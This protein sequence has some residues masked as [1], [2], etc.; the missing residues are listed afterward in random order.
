MPPLELSRTVG[1]PER[2]REVGE[3]FLG[4]FVDLCGLRPDERVL[5]VGSGVGRIA[6]PLAGYLESGTYEG[7]DVIAASVRWCQENITPRHPNFVFQHADVYNGS[8]NPTGTIAGRRLRVPVRGT[9]SFDFLYLAWIV[10][11]H[12]AAGRR[13]LPV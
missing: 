11:P 9:A 1:R 13:A 10:H 12:A 6:L 3:E 7:F 5:D 4:Y 2:F 8:Y